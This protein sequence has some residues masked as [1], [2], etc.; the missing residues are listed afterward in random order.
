MKI[1]HNCYNMEKIYSPTIPIFDT[2]IYQCCI[3]LYKKKTHT[4]VHVCTK[5]WVANV[6]TNE[7]PVL[8]V[9]VQ[10]IYGSSYFWDLLFLNRRLLYFTHSSIWTRYFSLYNAIVTKIGS[11]ENVCSSTLGVLPLAAQGFYRYSHVRRPTFSSLFH[12]TFFSQEEI[13][14]RAHQLFTITNFGMKIRS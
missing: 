5:M 9:E 11:S 14:Q 6:K 10:V 4:H 2:K 7:V 3:S 13:N 8:M 1:L 12:T